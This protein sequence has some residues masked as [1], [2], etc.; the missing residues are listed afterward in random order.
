MSWFYQLWIY[1]NKSLHVKQ[2]PSYL[3]IAHLQNLMPDSR[4][5]IAQLAATSLNVQASSSSPVLINI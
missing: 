4:S 1:V 5:S 3:P 2:I